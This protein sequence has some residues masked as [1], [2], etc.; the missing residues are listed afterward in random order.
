MFLFGSIPAPLGLGPRGLYP[1][2]R[3]QQGYRL[4]RTRPS[5]SRSPPGKSGLLCKARCPRLVCLAGRE[6]SWELTPLTCRALASSGP[7]IG[8]RIFT[9]FTVGPES[10]V[11]LSLRT[12]TRFAAPLRCYA[13]CRHPIHQ[14]ITLFYHMAWVVLTNKLSPQPSWA[15]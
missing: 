8:S 12:M 1:C 6:R 4:P 3:N 14:E 7:E 10:S 2:H 5:P 13:M 11:L 15:L 9:N